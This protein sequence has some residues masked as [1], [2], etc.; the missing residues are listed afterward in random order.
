MPVLLALLALTATA[1]YLLVVVDMT[2]QEGSVM[3]CSAL[4]LFP[5]PFVWAPFK[6]SGRRTLVASV[7]W[8]STLALAGL[9]LIEVEASTRAL[10]G[11]VQA[12]DSE[13]G[14][15]CRFTGDMSWTDD[16]KTILAVCSP[17]DL[18]KVEYRSADEMVTRYQGA[19]ADRLSRIYASHPTDS[20]L[21]LAIRSPSDLYACY[22]IDRSGRILE[23]WSS[24]PSEPCK[25]D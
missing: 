1:S 8:D 3:G 9:S 22:S 16:G 13:L 23:A 24:G 12:A 21:V 2:K 18:S 4:F 5:V 20:R 7:L 10:D 25:R 11:F 6:Y 17:P 19:F 15:S 14:I